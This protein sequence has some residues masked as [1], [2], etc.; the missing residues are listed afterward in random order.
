MPDSLRDRVRRLPFFPAARRVY[1]RLRRPVVR[2]PLQG[3]A[4]AGD[5]KLATLGSD[6]GGWTF[7][8][9]PK[10]FGTTIISAGLGEDASFDVEF[11]KNYDAR[12]IM[13]DPT[14][15]AIVHFDEIR[16]RLGKQRERDYVAGGRQPGE[17]YDL[18]GL[19]ESNF[20]LVPK[21]LW[22]DSTVLKF[23]QPADPEH[24]SH[25]LVNYQQNY[26]DDTDF[27]EVAS[28]TL[29][30][31]L[32]EV[33]LA[34]ADV[35]LIKLDIEGAEVEVLIQALDGEF[36]PAQILVEFDELNAPSLKA[37]ER[38]DH[39]DSKLRSCGYKP[40]YTDGASNFLY[41][42][43]NARWEGTEE[44]RGGERTSP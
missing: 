32:D 39:V 15:R 24:V 14:P 4:P 17:A 5:F 6:Y 35:Q 8:D 37:F 13:V 19:T 29:P 16:S 44:S 31:L 1:R 40:I 9:D 3:L 38:V 21:A 2:H 43:G 30:E 23:F 41:V 11:A 20:T 12:I 27:V 10:L 26:A 34:A 42:I 33:G 28:T 7:V 22:K 25:S 18:Y 36:R